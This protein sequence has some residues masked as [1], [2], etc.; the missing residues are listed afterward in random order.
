MKDK[1]YAILSLILVVLISLVGYSVGTI[2]TKKEACSSKGGV[3][4]YDLDLCYDK[5][6]LEQ[7]GILK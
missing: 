2:H 3:Y 7:L 1:E 6:K 5:G 4:N